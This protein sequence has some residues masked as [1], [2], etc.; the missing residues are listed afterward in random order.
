MK[1]RKVLGL[2][3]TDAGEKVEDAERLFGYRI[4]GMGVG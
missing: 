4:S 1:E 3:R 2:V